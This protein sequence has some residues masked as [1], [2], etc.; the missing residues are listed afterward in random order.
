MFR[1]LL[2]GLLAVFGF[3]AYIWYTAPAAK[4]DAPKQ[5]AQVPVSTT[6]AIRRDIP[7]LLSGIGT[8]QALNTV[9][10]RSRVDGTLDEVNFKEGQKVHQGDVLVRID[11]RLYK[12][13]LDQ[14]K[15]KLA[16]DQAQ[17]VSDQKDLERSQQLV[18]RQYAT[19]Q[20]VDQLTAKVGVDKALIEADKAQIA[21]AQTNL[22]YTT[23]TAPF[24]GMIGLRNID[25]GNIVH[26]SD[27]APIATLTQH[28]PIY[29][30]FTLPEAQF[31]QVR[32]ALHKGDVPTIAMDQN[33][34]KKI[35]SGSLRVVDNQID[36]TSG[37]IRLKAEFPNKDGALWPGQFA[38]IQIQVGV[39]KDSVVFPTAA[40]QRGP[41]GL[42]VWLA[43]PD[44]HAAMQPVQTGASFEGVTVAEKGISEG[45]RIITSNQYK[46][47]PNV[48][49]RVDVQ[50]VAANDSSGR[51]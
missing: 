33:G 20:S 26:A 11:P 25:P 10:I 16:Q 1:F 9:Q 42:Y 29:V 4:Q 13:A 8:V 34:K 46:L 32:D 47:H 40:L 41:D 21:S 37:T 24:T 45:D 30:L 51:T 43:K 15:A 7:V 38:P 49:I 12:A 19:Q 44:G 17:L 2:V 22:D 31:E 50:P 36:Q 48:N 18:T 39:E 23:I 5:P 27:T 28:E 3:S 6:L 35:A 14:A